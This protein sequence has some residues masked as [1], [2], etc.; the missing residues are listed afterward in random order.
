MS[1]LTEIIRAKVTAPT[2][3]SFATITTG[4]KP[5]P[6]GSTNAGDALPCY[7]AMNCIR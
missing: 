7:D 6:H 2:L 3:G 1:R 4:G 5:Q